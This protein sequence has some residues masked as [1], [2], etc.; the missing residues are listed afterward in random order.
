MVNPFRFLCLSALLSLAS[1]HAAP[2]DSEGIWAAP[3]P[4][5][6][7]ENLKTR[8]RSYLSK[9]QTRDP[10]ELTRDSTLVAEYGDVYWQLRELIDNR[11]PIHGLEDLGI[12]TRP[13]GSV[14]IDVKRFPQWSPLSD[15]LKVIQSRRDVED[16]APSL[17][18][19]GF[20]DQDFEALNTYVDTHDRKRL[21]VAANKPLVEQ[22]AKL[23]RSKTGASIPQAKAHSYRLFRSTNEVSRVWAEGLMLSLRPQAQRILQSTLEEAHQSI[24][25]APSANVEEDLRQEMSVIRSEGFTKAMENMEKESTP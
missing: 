8:V 5:I 4:V 14:E 2:I 24:I 22:Y 17:R 9:A 23:V 3:P 11:K 12:A 1:A 21:M 10:V 19:R 6:D 15:L 18:E 25:I 7:V 16:F 13:S 20:E